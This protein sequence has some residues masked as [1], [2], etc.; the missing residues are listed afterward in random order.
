MTDE[1]GNAGGYAELGGVRL[2]S[3]ADPADPLSHLGNTAPAI[4]VAS[5]RT[6]ADGLAMLT[7]MPR[8]PSSSWTNFAGAVSSTLVQIGQLLS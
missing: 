6:R 2:L 1:I 7:A 3:T 4:A 8:R 5:G